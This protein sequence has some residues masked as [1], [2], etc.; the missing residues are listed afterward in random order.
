MRLHSAGWNFRALIAAGVIG[1]VLLAS[2]CKVPRQAGCEK[3]EDRPYIDTSLARYLR[4][5]SPKDTPTYTT[6]CA[7]ELFAP[8]ARQIA[9][10][11]KRLGEDNAHTVLDDA[12]WYTHAA[13]QIFESHEI[14]LPLV[15]TQSIRFVGEQTWMLA[16]QDLRDQSAYL[17][18]HPTRGLKLVYAVDVDREVVETFFA[19]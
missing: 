11:K 14:P 10:L 12:N 7:V 17:L 13:R 19:P 4:K 1:T 2:A 6:A 5:N 3:E 8:S 18:F 16:I 15:R 9:L